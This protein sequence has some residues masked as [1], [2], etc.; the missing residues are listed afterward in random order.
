MSRIEALVQRYEAVDRL[1][2]E[3]AEVIAA[4]D[5]PGARYNAALRRLLFAKLLDELIAAAR[6]V[7]EEE[8]PVTDTL[9]DLIGLAS[10]ASC[11]LVASG[12]PAQASLLRGPGCSARRTRTP[13]RPPGR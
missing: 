1:L 3:G 10:P 9:L 2:K 11:V 13:P 12:K 6:V 5:P 8:T 7:A 4:P